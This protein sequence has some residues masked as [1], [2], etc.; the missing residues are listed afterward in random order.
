ML[1]KTQRV[2]LAYGIFGQIKSQSGLM[3]VIVREVPGAV[4]HKHRLKR[5]WRFLSN[6]LIKPNGLRFSWINWCLK[7]FVSGRIIPAA[8]DWT[9]LPG[10]IQCLMIAIPFHGRAIPLLWHI[11]LHSRIKDSQNAI[12]ERL[13]ARLINLTHDIDPA[14]KLLITADRGFGRAT[15]FQFLQKRGVLFVIRVKGDVTITTKKGKRHLLGSIGK[16]LKQNKPVWYEKIAYRGDGKVTGINLACVIAPPKDEGAKPDPWLLVTNLRKKET[17]IKRYH[18][19]FHIEEWFKDMKY[20]LG[21]AKLQTRSLMRVRRLL[22]VSAIAYGITML[23]GTVAKR[24]TTVQDQL[25]TGGKKVASRIWFALNIIKHNLLGNLFW[26]KVY[27]HATV[28]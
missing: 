7:T 13:L 21:I 26:K 5:F 2:N 1:R 11:T 12:E 24:F 20:Q 18:D 16:T 10:N 3:S 15:L 14:R 28:P 4:K 6:P 19:R 23:I 25:I 22:W 27:R 17:A 8:I 9:T